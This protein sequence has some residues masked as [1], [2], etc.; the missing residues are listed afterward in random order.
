MLKVINL[1]KQ[2]WVV[3]AAASSGIVEKSTQVPDH[4]NL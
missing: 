4:G 3:R 2:D 1:K